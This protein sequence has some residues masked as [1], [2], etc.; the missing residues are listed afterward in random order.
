LLQEFRLWSQPL[1]TSSFE[2]H[3]FNP[4]SYEG[5]TT[6]SA[7]E[8]L[9][10][11]LPLGNDLKINY[12]M[13]DYIES[14][15]P[16]SSPSYLYTSSFNNPS[17]SGSFIS[18]T[19][20][21]S[22]EPFTE[23]YYF[24]SPNTGILERTNNKI[25]IQSSSIE[26]NVL[27]ALKRIEQT[28]GTDLTQDLH[29]AEIAFSPQNEINDDIISQLGF[30]NIDD[31]IGNP[32]EQTLNQYPT[33]EK[34]KEY[35]FKK[36]IT[37]YN[38]FDYIRLIKYFDNSLFKMIKDFI[39]GRANTSTGI[40]IKPHILERNK[41]QRPILSGENNYFTCSIFIKDIEGDSGGVVEASFIGF[42]N[43]SSSIQGNLGI[44]N[45]IGTYNEEYYNGEY[46]GSTISTL[47]KT[48][49]PFALLSYN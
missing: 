24:N 20:S 34:L 9:L 3:T 29:L 2:Y 13:G 49:N 25:R 33:L 8:T 11:R 47:K 21:S 12:N 41:I 35:Y 14:S 46:E 45:Q 6:G 5:N 16:A 42:N 1:V 19:L 40:V 31:Y 39:P 15:H 44:I 48:P 17:L 38:A 36:Y 10:L 23:Q 28:S 26:N 43:F 27:S 7:H 32:Q 22:F 18:G 37:N 4:Q 30:F